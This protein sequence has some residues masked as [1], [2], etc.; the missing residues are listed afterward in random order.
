MGDLNRMP[1]I[2]KKT[3][4][5]FGDSVD[6]DAEVMYDSGYKWLHRLGECRFFLPGMER[7]FSLSFIQSMSLHR[8]ME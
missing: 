3:D 5:L 6:K 1:Y 8:S 2:A 4:F 7:M